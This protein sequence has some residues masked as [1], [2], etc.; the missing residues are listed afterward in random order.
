M[1]KI[2]YLF[3][4]LFFFGIT[5]SNAQNDCVDAIIVCGNTGFEGLSATG[6]GTQELN[7]NN[8]CGSSE[9]NTIWLQLSIASAGT[10]GFTLTP[11]STNLEVDFD[12]FIYGPNVACGNIGQ[13]IRCSTTNPL[14][15]GATTNLTGLSETET[16]FS[17]GPGPAG[18]NFVQ[19]L[20]VN[21]GETYFLI[22]DRPIGTSNFSLTWTGTATFN[23][24]PT[25]EIPA[26]TGLDIEKCDVDAI[27]DGFTNF[28]LEENKI[29]NAELDKELKDIIKS[30]F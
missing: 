3:L 12:F 23:Q 6:V 13:A 24:P 27:Q 28:D 14:A 30:S 4:F 15:S 22:I 11:E 25:F 26:G 19:W 18:N 17:E 8:T 9:N 21:S 1:I 2:N 7:G 29:S 5:K 20:T 10:L 16:D